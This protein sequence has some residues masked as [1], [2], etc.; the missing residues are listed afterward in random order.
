M[1]ALYYQIPVHLSPTTWE[2]RD[3]SSDKQV[4]DSQSPAKKPNPPQTSKKRSIPYGRSHR[5]PF[6]TQHL[7]QLKLLSGV[8][9]FPK[10]KNST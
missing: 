8:E 4:Q 1:Q 2:I 6:H 5:N 9:A 10:N 3:N 7:S